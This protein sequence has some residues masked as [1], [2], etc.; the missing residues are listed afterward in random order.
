MFTIIKHYTPCFKAC[1]NTY[2]LS[3]SVFIVSELTNA[4]WI[5]G[6]FSSLACTSF[7]A[8]WHT[9]SSAGSLLGG[10]MTSCNGKQSAPEDPVVLVLSS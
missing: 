8:W 10:M 9:V 3:G 2:A 5:L 1:F 7:W 4:A 6:I